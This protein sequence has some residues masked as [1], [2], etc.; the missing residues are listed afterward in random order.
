MIR[1]FDTILFGRITYQLFEEYWPKAAM[2]PEI[3]KENKIIADK[4]NEMTKVVFSKYL[5]KVTWNNSLLFHDNLEEEVKKLKEKKG[6]DIVIY[7][8]GTIAR[9]LAAAGLIDEYRLMVNPVILGKGK[10]LFAEIRHKINLTLIKTK[11][12]R[13]GNVLLYYKPL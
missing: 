7:G 13:G 2:D 3:S 10:N 8:S 1:K 12:F 5:K 11:P 4:I 6:S 9:Q